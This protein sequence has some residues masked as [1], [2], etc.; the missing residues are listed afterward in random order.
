MG[1]GRLQRRHI[2]T[3]KWIEPPDA[4]AILRSGAHLGGRVVDCDEWAINTHTTNEGMGSLTKALWQH[5]SAA[6]SRTPIMCDDITYA[7]IICGVRLN[8]NAKGAQ[9]TEILVFDP[10]VTHPTSGGDGGIKIQH[11]LNGTVNK[12][13]TNCSPPQP[14]G[15]ARW[16][17]LKTFFLH[18]KRY[19][20]PGKI[21]CRTHK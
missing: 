14:P 16:C 15:C 5:F 10:H 3:C 1:L 19:D 18:S 6:G 20:V 12:V 21:P 7:Y 13:F 4:A 17:P 9:H 11:F 8:F 2:G